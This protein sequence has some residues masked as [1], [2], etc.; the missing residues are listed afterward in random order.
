[1]ERDKERET[2]IGNNRFSWEDKY[3]VDPDINSD[4]LKRI[5]KYIYTLKT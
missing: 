3:W 2:E 5:V 4:F 1:M